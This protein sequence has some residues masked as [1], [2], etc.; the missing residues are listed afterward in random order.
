MNRPTLFFCI[1]SSV[2]ALASCST[3]ECYDNRNAL[4]LADL[5]SSEPTPQ[6]ISLDSISVWGVGVPRDSMLLDAARNVQQIYLPFSIE[7]PSASFVIRYDALRRIDPSV[8]DDTL[9]F[10]YK[11]RPVFESQACGVFYRFD[12]IAVSHTSFLIDSVTCPKG[13]IDNSPSA[14][15]HIYFRVAASSVPSRH[16]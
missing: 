16:Q 2:L 6:R 8:P 9:S 5:Y 12:D 10:S 4:P 1:A 14:N 13:Y 11:Q 3:D 7:R 15:L